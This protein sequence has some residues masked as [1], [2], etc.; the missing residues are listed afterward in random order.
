MT[1]DIPYFFKLKES[2]LTMLSF[3][4][5]SLVK[6]PTPDPWRL[7]PTMK[8]RLGAMRAPSE[9]RRFTLEPYK[10]TLDPWRLA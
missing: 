7:T 10:L 9:T 5:A 1:E 8:V 6:A 2:S 4:P 3:M